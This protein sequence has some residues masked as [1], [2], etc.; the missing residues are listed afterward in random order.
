VNPKTSRASQD[1]FLPKVFPENVRGE[2]RERNRHFAPCLL[3]IEVTFQLFPLGS[4]PTNFTFRA[5][6]LFIFVAQP[7]S[8]LFCSASGHKMKF[9][10]LPLKCFYAWLI[11]IPQQHKK[12]LQIVDNIAVLVFC[13]F[14]YILCTFF[15]LFAGV[16]RSGTET[17][18]E[19]IIFT[20]NPVRR[21]G[22]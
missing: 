8:L 16:S 4:D 17:G 7:I 9:N 22:T 18:Q 14:P 1:R 6:T 20:R 15:L 19:I 5:K 10:Y 2:I 3:P 12:P 21:P 13:V 11:A